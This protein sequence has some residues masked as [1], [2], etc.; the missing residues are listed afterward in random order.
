MRAAISG[1]GAFTRITHLPLLSITEEH[2]NKFRRSAIAV[3]VLLAATACDSTTEPEA[4]IVRILPLIYESTIVVPDTVHS[5]VPFAINFDVNC[6]PAFRASLKVEHYATE[7]VVLP[8]C[9]GDYT[10]LAGTGEGNPTEVR[11]DLTLRTPGRSTVKM[12]GT[13]GTFE[14]TV[15]VLEKT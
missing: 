10:D 14:R 8:N 3:A 15:Q 2:V 6:H 11:V 5:A 1:D 4:D 9:V 12:V 7:I 13:N